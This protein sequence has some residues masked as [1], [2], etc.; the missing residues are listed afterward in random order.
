ML[1]ISTMYVMVSL[2]SLVAGIIHVVPWA[3]GRF[4]RWAAWWGFGHILLGLTAA[5]A[6]YREFGGG[7]DYIIWLG[8][9]LAV[10]AY[11]AIFVGFRSFA[12]PDSDNRLLVAAALV[13]GFPL[14][15]SVRPEELGFR[16]GYLS[17]LRAA[18]DLAIVMIAVRLARRDSLHTAWMV[19]ALF[20]PTV[21]LFL[22]RAWSAFHGDI[23]A[24]VMGIK[25]GAA[26]W[27]TVVPISFI[28][29]RGGVSLLTMDAERGHQRLSA[30]LERDA[31]TGAY[32]RTGYERQRSQWCGEGAV[33][34]IDLDQFK[35]LNDRLGHASGDAALVALVRSA[36]AI[37]PG[38]SP[39]FRWGGD[40][41]V[42][43]LPGAD[44]ATANRMTAAITDRYRTEM[45]AIAPADLPVALSIGVATGPL[46][47]S[48]DLIVAADHAMYAIK[49]GRGGPRNTALPDLALQVA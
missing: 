22:A 24:S 23:G 30:L 46:A 18:F 36:Q 15:F 8:N 2:A 29:F 13:L 21:P 38:A 9:P 5:G 10:M 32:N 14:Y 41:F 37:L 33:L 6:I 4:D 28:L 40:E 11:V 26:A 48:G 27:L 35:P 34:M 7:G 3:S 44:R 45:A 12:D 1:D 43:V 20:T 39:V 31:L 47:R 25:G 42:C 19:V 16:V 49:H 17:I